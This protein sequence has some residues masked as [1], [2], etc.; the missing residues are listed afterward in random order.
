MSDAL[1]ALSEELGVLPEWHD[2]AGKRHVTGPD[3]QRALLT[4]MG[5]FVADDAEAAET[6]AGR[7]AERAARRL[8]AEVIA[9]AGQELRLPLAAGGGSAQWRLEL[10]DGNLQEGRAETEIVV[11]PPPGLHHLFAGDERCLVIAAPPRAPTVPEALGRPQA[12]GVTAALYGLRSARNLGIG[13]YADLAA[14]AEQFGRLGADFLGVNPLHAHGAACGDISPYTPSCRTAFDPRHIAVDRVPGF[15]A[16]EAARALL[17]DNAARLAA[18]RSD[19]LVDYRTAAAIGEDVLRALF[20]DFERSAGPATD[21]FARWRAG[22][23]QAVEWFALFEAISLRHGA[24]W[25]RWPSALRRF[26]SPAVLAFGAANNREVRYHAWLQWLADRQLGAA[27]RSA[28]DAGMGLGL[29]LDVAVGVRPDGADTW[30]APGCFAE[31]VSL[32]APPDA[33]NPAGQNWAL[34]PFSPAGLHRAGYRPFVEMLRTAMRHAGIVRID[35]ILGLRRSFWMP[36]DGTPGGYVAYPEEALLALVRLEAW[37]SGCLVV[38]EDL[39]SVPPGLRDR[40]AGSGLY[41]CAV[42]QFEAEHHRFRPPRDYRPMTLASFG[43]HDTP[44]LRGWWS[45]W[46]IDRRHEINGGSEADRT[47]AQEARAADRRALAGLLR[48]EGVAPPALD[49]EAPPRQADDAIAAS[50]HRLLAT[51]GSA[52]VAVQLDDAL[53]AKTQ[54]NLPGTVDEHPNWRRRYAVN[55]ESLATHPG[56]QAAAGLFA[57]PDSRNSNTREDHPWP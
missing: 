31:G 4:A 5:L 29:Y 54:Q 45:G 20:A 37:R 22:P 17:R 28:L 14:A 16:C 49:P 52:L 12:W 25:R 18:A 41:G 21:G 33:F 57:P 39:G 36:E 42:V 47:A 56:V 2:V 11:T 53:G 26:G 24:D 34:A 6:L 3:T 8:P 44:T 15:A 38:G 48:D 35:H 50:V 46:D 7:R 27:Q 10:E 1:Q 32:G 43:T 30:S 40:L 9:A 19:E 23:G 13:D 55:V 51:A